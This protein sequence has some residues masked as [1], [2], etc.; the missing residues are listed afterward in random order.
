MRCKQFVIILNVE[1][2]KLSGQ[3]TVLFFTKFLLMAQKKVEN[4]VLTSR[5]VS[6]GLG[7]GLEPGLNE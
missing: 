5:W 7:G 4:P 2:V 3:T 6:C 1:G